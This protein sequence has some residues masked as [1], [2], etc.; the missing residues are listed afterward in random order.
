MSEQSGTGCEGWNE[1][2]E[3]HLTEKQ[4]QQVAKRPS[5]EVHQAVKAQNRAKWIVNDLE[6]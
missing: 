5:S 1:N 3:D 6:D 4:S 2:L